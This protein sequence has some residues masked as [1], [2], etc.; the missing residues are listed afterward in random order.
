MFVC[1]SYV[2]NCS[3]SG[4]T[5]MANIFRFRQSSSF[6]RGRGE[7]GFCFGDKLVHSSSRPEFQT[8]IQ[9]VAGEIELHLWVYQ[10]YKEDTGP[11]F[12]CFMLQL[13]LIDSCGITPSSSLTTIIASYTG[14][15]CPQCFFLEKIPLLAVEM[16]FRSFVV[17]ALQLPQVL[18]LVLAPVIPRVLFFVFTPLV[19]RSCSLYWQYGLHWYFLFTVVT[20]KSVHRFSTSTMNAKCRYADHVIQEM[21]K[22]LI[23][24]FVIFQYLPVGGF[25]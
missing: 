20:D 9:A 21:E 24:F 13:G 14:T 2:H 19:N 5:L 4:H 8:R 11:V 18:K 22:S 6:V 16:R 25:A 17:L 23:H 1:E 7:E 10:I 15:Y 3:P 12:I